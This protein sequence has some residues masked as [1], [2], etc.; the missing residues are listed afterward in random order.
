M[1][2]AHMPRLSLRT[3]A[4]AKLLACQ[5]VEKR[6]TRQK[7]SPRH[8]AHHAQGETD[9]ALEQAPAQDHQ[10]EAQADDRGERLERVQRGGIAQ[11]RGIGQSIDH[12]PGKQRQGELGRGDQ[13]QA[14]RHG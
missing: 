14:S 3:V 5:S 13:H 12:L 7:V 1:S 4:P 2:K 9:D 8:L 10:G 11:P 6:C